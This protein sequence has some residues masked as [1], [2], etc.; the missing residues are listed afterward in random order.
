MNPFQKKNILLFAVF[1]LANLSFG[2]SSSHEYRNIEKHAK[3]NWQA[4]NLET[5]LLENYSELPSNGH[6]FAIRQ[7][8][9]LLGYAYTGR[10]F[11]CR[12][13]GCSATASSAG[14]DNYEYFDYLILYNPSLS[15][16]LVRVYNYQATHGHQICNPSWL[17]QFKNYNGL[18]VLQYGSDIDAISGATIS[19]IS[20]ISDIE[21]VS[22]IVC[23]TLIDE[24][25]RTSSDR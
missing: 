3:K 1:L 16:D 7:N 15:I 20:I 6:I 10:V 12:E 13:G 11:S 14:S 24:V 9:F 23:K 5:T 19:A 8:H 17:N 4:D 2:Q 25:E 21:R 22:A 18:S